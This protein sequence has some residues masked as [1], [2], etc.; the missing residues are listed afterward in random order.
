MLLDVECVSYAVTFFMEALK[1]AYYTIP[2]K[3]EMCFVSVATRKSTE[4]YLMLLFFF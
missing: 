1:E 4:T 3:Y 2:I